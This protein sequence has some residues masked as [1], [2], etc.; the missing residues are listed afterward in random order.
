M[1]NSKSFLLVFFLC[2]IFLLN[3][4]GQAGRNNSAD[5]ANNANDNSLSG[6][7]SKLTT[8]A[9]KLP[10]EE[11]IEITVGLNY[12]KWTPTPARDYKGVEFIAQSY[13]V[14]NGTET[15]YSS[16]GKEFVQICF[17]INDNKR[18]ESRSPVASGNYHLSTSGAPVMG[19]IASISVSVRKDKRQFQ[20]IFVDKFNTYGN[21]TLESASEKF[22]SGKFS[23]SGTA[24]SINGEFGV[25]LSLAEPQ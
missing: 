20:D 24:V 8:V 5:A 18:W 12:G 4:C 9:L 13:C 17:I 11:P 19:Q 6:P 23:F 14:S 3:S 16:P 10:N 7:P 21:L 15:K 1:K 2:S 25:N 22:I